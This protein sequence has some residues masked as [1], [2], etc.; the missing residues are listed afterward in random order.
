MTREP[1]LRD[2]WGRFRD[3]L[4]AF[5]ALAAGSIDTASARETLARIDQE[6][7]RQA[8]ELGLRWMRKGTVAGGGSVETW[9]AARRDEI[10]AAVRTRRRRLT[11]GIAQS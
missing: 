3:C 5:E 1:S 10:A 7:G 4:A 2:L 8:R 11:K 9:R 6:L